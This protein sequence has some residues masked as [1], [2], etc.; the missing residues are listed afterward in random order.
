MADLKA[1]TVVDLE[2]AREAPFGYFLSNGREDVLL[3]ES[4]IKGHV[5]INDTLEVFLYQDKLGRLAATMTIPEIQIGKYGWVKVV[6]VHDNLGAFVNIG[7]SKDILIHKDDLPKLKQTWP[8]VGGKLYC[9]LK[10]DKNGRLLGKLAT[11]DIMTTLFEKANREAFNKT[12]KGTV[13]R[14]LRSGTF[15]ITEENYR[16]FIHESQ[17][18]KEPRVGDEVEGRIIDVKSDGTVNISLLPRNFESLQDDAEK[19]FAYLQQRGGSMPYWDKSYPEEIEKRF[20]MSKAAFKRA[21]GKLMKEGK[22]IQENGW[23]HLKKDKS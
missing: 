5:S 19:V 2:V 6:D 1:G 4:E 8:A 16:G 21:L 13:Y 12:V 18:R 11:E 22:I 23:T 15:I 7:I 10:T 14:T 20:Q 17:R 3:H 9:T